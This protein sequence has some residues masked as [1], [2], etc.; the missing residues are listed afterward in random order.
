MIHVAEQM[1]FAPDEPLARG[2]GAIGGGEA[3]I[4]GCVWL[5]DEEF[6]EG[7][8]GRCAAHLPQIEGS[9]AAGINARLRLFRCFP[10]PPSD[11]LNLLIRHTFLRLNR[12]CVIILAAPVPA[13]GSCL[14]LLCCAPR[15]SCPRLPTRV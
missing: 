4:D 2:A 10:F 7:I 6:L 13:S 3:Q 5:A 1:G 15:P 8:F 9:V 14:L 11:L 12:P